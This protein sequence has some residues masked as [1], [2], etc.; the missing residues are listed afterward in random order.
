MANKKDTTKKKTTPKT[1]KSKKKNDTVIEIP[2][3]LNEVT[4]AMLE[5]AELEG[6]NLELTFADGEKVNVDITEMANPV[7]EVAVV[8]F[9]T[10][11]KPVE[12]ES[13]FTKK[14]KET[15]KNKFTK[16]FGYLWNGQTM[17]D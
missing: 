8:E 6:S 12:D 15:I 4:P 14:Q 9:P 16:Y 3:K 1:T 11:P 7:E 2:P 5:N 10:E 17:D 13:K